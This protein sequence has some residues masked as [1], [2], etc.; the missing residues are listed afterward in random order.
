ME[1]P[2]GGVFTGSGLSHNFPVND[3]GNIALTAAVDR[4]GDTGGEVLF[5]DK[6]ADRWT[7]VMKKGMPAPGG[8]EFTGNDSFAAMNRA[9]DIL[10]PGIV[11]DSTAGPAGTGMFLYSGGQ[12]RTVARP[13]TAVPS[14]TLT[15]AYRPQLTDNGIATFE[16]AV[17][18]ASTFGAYMW[19]DG[20]LTELAAAGGPVPGSSDTFETLRGPQA[21]SSG[22]VVML[23]QVN[24][25]WGIYLYRASE[26]KL[27][28]VVKPGDV[29]PG[30]GTVASAEGAGRNSTRLAEDGSILFV[31]RM[32]DDSEGVFLLKDGQYSAVVRS[33]QEMKDVG[34]LAYVT[35]GNFG[36]RTSYGLGWNSKG[37]IVFPA[38]LAGDQIHL[39]MATPDAPAVAPAQPQ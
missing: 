14:G 13:G 3:A 38:V 28:A 6:A 25:D 29:L 23:G 36:A 12:F 21:N 9:N 15:R 17:D 11:T 32:E 8:G 31:A 20:V 33:G 24:G 4:G 30:I 10:I 16:G 5:Y 2:A 39:V 26:Q 35:S 34:T 19:R 18:G 22:D 37:Q 7:V 1:S 27:T